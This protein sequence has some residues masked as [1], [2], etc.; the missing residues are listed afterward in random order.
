MIKISEHRSPDGVRRAEVWMREDG[1][2]RV[3]FF[4]NTKTIHIFESSQFRDSVENIA[5]SFVLGSNS[6]PELLLG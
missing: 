3:L 6:L 4:E 2:Y 1:I 5:E